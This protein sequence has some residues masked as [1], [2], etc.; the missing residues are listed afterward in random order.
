MALPPSAA[1]RW[2]QSDPNVVY[3]GTGEA[4][5]R[6]NIS[7]GDGVWKSIDAGKTWKNVGLKDSRAIGKVI[8][9]PR[10]PDIV[11]VAA[12][13]HPFGPNTERGVFRSTDGGKTWD[14][15]LYKDENT[16]AIDVAFD[17]Q[18]ANIVFASLWETRRTPWSLS[19]G[20]PGS[21]LYR[22]TDGGTTWKRLSKS[23]DCRRVPTDES[24]WRWQR[25]RIAC[26]RSSR[27]KRV[28]SIART[29]AATAGI[30]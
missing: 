23:T 16:G 7:D 15:V 21:G 3:V 18:N 17:P 2:R 14:K 10:N 8:V 29:M 22:S 13:G 26:T 30:W 12:L 25:T 27:R 28:A 24:V 1:W 4:C 9:H 6:G 19:S 11:F 20:G 5:I